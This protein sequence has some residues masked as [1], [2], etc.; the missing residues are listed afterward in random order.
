MRGQHLRSNDSGPTSCFSSR[1][2]D[3]IC[4]PLVSDI[5]LISGSR[6][7]E[8]SSMSCAVDVS[9]DRLEVSSDVLLVIGFAVGRV[10]WGSDDPHPQFWLVE[11]LTSDADV[12]RTRHDM[13]RLHPIGYTK[14]RL[15]Y[16]HYARLL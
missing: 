7:D 13:L 4:A 10:T 8:W 12:G 16:L 15:G 5:F 3:R 2:V 11:G 14:L 1:D 6:S 9:P